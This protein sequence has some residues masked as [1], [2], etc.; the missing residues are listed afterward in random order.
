MTTLARM[1]GV[2]VAVGLVL[3]NEGAVTAEETSGP[4]PVTVVARA[5]NMAELVDERDCKLFGPDAATVPTLDCLAC[6]RLYRSHP[7]DIE[8]D[9]AA[10][11]RPNVLRAQP[12]ALKRGA[13]LPAGQVHCT[14]CH[15]GSSPW[16]YRVALPPGSELRPAVD[17]RRPETYEGKPA[18][19]TVPPGAAVG[20][21]PLCTTC[22][23]IGD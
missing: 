23:S 4:P 20:T 11:R 2:L 5:W 22:H 14:S 13:R 12:D 18:Q 19:R 10:Q 17:P 21:K 7:V 6:H 15:D 16:M 9:L 8:Y 3:W 1:S